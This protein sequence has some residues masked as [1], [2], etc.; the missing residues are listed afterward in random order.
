MTKITF[1]VK[2]NNTIEYGHKEFVLSNLQEDI[3]NLA[4]IVYQLAKLINQLSQYE[5]EVDTELY[6][7]LHEYAIYLAGA[8]YLFTDSENK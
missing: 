5:E 6:N 1:N 4:E 2:D 7:L 3:K 8:A